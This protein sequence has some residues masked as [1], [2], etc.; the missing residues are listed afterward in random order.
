MTF[1]SGIRVEVGCC[2]SVR[3]RSCLNM[4]SGGEIS[5]GG[6]G[7]GLDDGVGVWVEVCDPGT[8]VER[9]SDIRDDS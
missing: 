2:R 4:D 7:G 3:R 8:P 6:C 9:G 5:A 1:T